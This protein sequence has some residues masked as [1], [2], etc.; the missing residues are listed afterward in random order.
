MFN[1]CGGNDLANRLSDGDVGAGVVSSGFYA[2][3]TAGLA[4]L[5][6][7]F[8]QVSTIFSIAIY[9]GYSNRD[10]GSYTLKD[11]AGNILGSWT[12]ATSSNGTNLGT[13]AFW[14]AFKNPV[15]TNQL[16]FNTTSTESNSTNSFREIQVFVPEPA[17]CWRFCFSSQ[18]PIMLPALARSSRLRS[19]F[20]F[21]VCRSL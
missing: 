12:I 13:D 16:V 11:S 3:P 20:L 6:L 9:N 15:A 17:A 21:F 5:T 19:L 10:D 4:S 8:S 2:I 14:L 18:L 7:T 1:C